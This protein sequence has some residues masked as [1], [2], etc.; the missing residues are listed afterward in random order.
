MDVSKAVWDILG[1]RARQISAEGWS[2]SHDDEHSDGILSRAAACY[3]LRPEERQAAVSLHL[4][5][6]H[7][8]WPWTPSDWKPRDRRRD[9][10]RAGALII[11]ELERLDR[12]EAGTCAN[13]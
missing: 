4:T 12:K 2:Q 11:A 13:K 8:L 1:E 6:L 9:L 3:A 7:R 10:V 5:L